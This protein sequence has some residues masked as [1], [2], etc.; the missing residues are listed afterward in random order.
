MDGV[1]LFS[2]TLSGAMLLVVVDEKSGVLRPLGVE[3]G[4]R[5]DM[6]LGPAVLLELE[7]VLLG[8]D[9]KEE[10]D[11]DGPPDGATV[12]GVGDG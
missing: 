4:P 7:L 3:V 2:F 6:V 10:D 11:D 8:A 9:N 12:A 1:L 5:R